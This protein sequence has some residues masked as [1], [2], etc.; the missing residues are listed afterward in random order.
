MENKSFLGFFFNYFMC[1]GVLWYFACMY[2]CHRQ[3]L[4]KPEDGVGSLELEVLMVV[5]TIWVLGS[6]SRSFR[7]HPS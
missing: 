1:I 2:V 4:W 3:Y 5:D 6:D 7:S